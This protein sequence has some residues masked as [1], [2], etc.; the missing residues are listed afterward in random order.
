M[1]EIVDWS[2]YRERLGSAI[3]KIITIPAAMQ[4]VANPVARVKHPDWLHKQVR[5]GRRAPEAGQA[6][7]TGSLRR[8]GEPTDSL[9]CGC[10]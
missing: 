10:R 5:G 1:R 8:M 4:L 9:I 6:G 3:Q 2:Y 7:Q